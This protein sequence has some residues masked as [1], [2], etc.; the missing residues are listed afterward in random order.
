M[1]LHEGT[2]LIG[3]W[4]SVVPVIVGILTLILILILTLIATSSSSSTTPLISW[5]MLI[6][7][8][9]YS[10]LPNT[11]PR[12]RTGNQGWSYVVKCP[13]GWLLSSFGGGCWFGPS[14]HLCRVNRLKRDQCWDGW[15][16]GEAESGGVY[17]RR[18]GWACRGEFGLFLLS[19]RV[20]GGVLFLFRRERRRN[21]EV[22]SQGGKSRRVDVLWGRAYRR[23][24]FSLQ[25][26][27]LL[28]V[29][30]VSSS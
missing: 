28:R 15:G 5:A 24:S 23:L 25:S 20:S 1:L 16:G 10:P 14:G 22:G 2:Y 9:S 29:F 4:D 30:S 26:D 6:A 11:S 19:L 8:L 21:W 17:Q 18:E 12:R 3:N 27:L 13:R 7:P